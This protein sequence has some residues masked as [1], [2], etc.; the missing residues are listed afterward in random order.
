M[1]SVFN[2]LKDSIS[3]GGTAVSDFLSS[4]LAYLQSDSTLLNLPTLFLTGGTNLVAYTLV[5]LSL[6]HM[7]LSTLKSLSWIDAKVLRGIPSTV[8]KFVLEDVLVKK[9]L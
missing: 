9:V 6:L 3:S 4:S 2:S 1:I 8:L 5:L 7:L